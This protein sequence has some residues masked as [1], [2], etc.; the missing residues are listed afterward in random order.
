MCSSEKRFDCDRPIEAAASTG[1]TRIVRKLLS[2]IE[3]RFAGLGKNRQEEALPTSDPRHDSR[4]VQEMQNQL[5]C[6]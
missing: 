1:K 5:S 2:I 6:C 4:L 3:L